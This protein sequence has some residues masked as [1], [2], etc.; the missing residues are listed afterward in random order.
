MPIRR[1]M[2]VKTCQVCKKD[3]HP[4]RHEQVC[5]CQKCAVQANRVVVMRECMQCGKEFWAKTYCSRGKRHCSQ[6]CLNESLFGKG[7]CPTCGK[8]FVRGKKNQKYCS[9]ECQRKRDRALVKPKVGKK[10]GRWTVLETKEMIKRFKTK[11]A[12]RYV[13]VKCRCEC[14]TVKWVRYVYL[15]DGSGSCG[16]LT[17]EKAIQRGFDCTKGVLPTYM[18]RIRLGA[19]VRNL[20]FRVS[21]KWLRELFERQGRKCIFSGAELSFRTHSG[22]ENAH[23]K[24]T[25]SLDRIDSSKG[26]TKKNVQWVHKKLN[27]MKGKLSDEEFIEWCRCVAVHNNRSK[28][29][30]E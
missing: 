14:G 11:R 4:F 5:C 12:K 19:A 22:P 23:K 7:C 21:A 10:Y 26:Y 27:R 30:G 9:L 6:E 1:L 29:T 16:C 28:K 18:K 3:F 15:Q 24:I 25:A 2:I 20:T 13:N 8:L 17:R